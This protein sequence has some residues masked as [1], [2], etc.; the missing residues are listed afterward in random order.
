MEKCHQVLQSVGGVNEGA[1]KAKPS[2]SPS[3]VPFRHSGGRSNS[4][5]EGSASAVS[6]FFLSFSPY[7]H[8]RGFRSCRIDACFFGCSQAEVTQEYIKI[9]TALGTLAAKVDLAL[10]RDVPHSQRA[11]LEAS[12]EGIQGAPFLSS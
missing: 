5:K 11:T 10:T 12:I 4:V 7:R 3:A 8:L 9:I 2:A 6:S 1:K